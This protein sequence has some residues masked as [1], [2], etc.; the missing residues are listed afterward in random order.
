MTGTDGRGETG[1]VTL[2]SSWRGIIASFAGAAVVAAVGILVL[3]LNGARPVPVVLGTLGVLVLVG[4]AVDYPIASTFTTEAVERRTLLRRH[5]V[6]WSNVRQL[7]RTRP[8]FVASIRKLELGGLVAVIGKRRFLLVDQVESYDE[9]V[10]VSEVLTGTAAE[11]VLETVI[12]PGDHVPP[13]WTYRRS[14]WAPDRDD[15]R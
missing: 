9:F 10:A 14:R 7:T 13:T 4:V 12:E 6:P 15:G 3:I 1:S 2:H 5:R 8:G 11:H